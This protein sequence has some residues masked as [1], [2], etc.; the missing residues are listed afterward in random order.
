MHRN[1]HYFKYVRS[2]FLFLIPYIKF[3]M[4]DLEEFI[5]ICFHWFILSPSDSHLLE[6]ELNAL[7]LAV[8]LLLSLYYVLIFQLFNLPS[9]ILICTQTFTQ[10]LPSHLDLVS[11]LYLIS[12]LQQSQKSG[13][14][15][16]YLW[17]SVSLQIKVLFWIGFKIH[18]AQ[19]NSIVG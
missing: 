16:R 7:I 9:F 3:L 15:P 14:V 18:I 19:Q 17:Y 5:Q 6:L 1:L 10:P 2:S 11:N 4:L 12:V 8:K 13:M